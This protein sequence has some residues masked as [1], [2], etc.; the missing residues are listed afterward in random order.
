V[1]R[2]GARPVGHGY[3]EFRVWAPRPKSVAVRVGSSDHAM[4]PVGDGVYE[5]VAPALAGD[6]YLF[7]L[8]GR[9]TL[10]DPCSRW[11]P[12][13]LRGPSR[14]LAPPAVEQFRPPALKDL[15]IYELHV[16][17]FTQEGTFDAAIP[18][19]PEL[20][21][22]GV[23]AVELMP[24]AEFPGD[25][26]W[27]YDG[28]YISAAQ[29]SYGGPEALQRFVEAAHRDGLAVILDVVYNHVGASGLKALEAFAPY[30]TK[31]T[32]WGP[33]LDFSSG[34]VREWV[35]QSAVG[36]IHDF[37]IDGLR[38]DAIHAIVDHSAEH[39]VEAIAREVHGSRPEALVI[40]EIGLADPD[41]HGGPACDAVWVDDFHHALH[42]LLTGERDGYYAPFGKVAQLADAFRRTPPGRFVVY[43]QNHDQ[44][45]NR[46]FGDRLPVHAQALAAL[47]TLC[48]P[49]VPL[50]FMGEDYGER[51]PF[52]FFSDHIDEKV[53]RATRLGRR[54]EFADFV[55]FQEQIPDPQDPETFRRSKLTG[56]R[57]P[58]LESLYRELL[59]LR[60]ELPRGDLNRIELDERARWLRL[61]RGPFE[62]ILNFGTDPLLLP[63]D[64]CRI[65]IATD[66]TTT[67]NDHHLHLA[68]LSGALVG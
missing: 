51:A 15:V 41:E 20:A 16:G 38:L 39:I 17:A 26:G 50:L 43:S 67:V 4:A 34:A 68:P 45:G 1:K 7:V 9:R 27:G 33:A 31:R 36:W 40:G 44:V 55:Q 10:P 65:R 54:E 57:D 46:A 8:N 28:V 3:V 21:S 14:V 29:S 5:V 30:F 19:L 48:S 64:G 58:R 52:Q 49:H 23:T 62:L 47:C 63:C 6:D 13:G 35:L 61:A 53:A 24:V 18:C 66:P 42:A 60:R 2:F 22:L 32:P 59:A 25:H 12:Q 56:K 37:G 11:Q